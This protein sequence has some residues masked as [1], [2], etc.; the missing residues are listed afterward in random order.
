MAGSNAGAAALVAA[1]AIVAVVG[2]G[3]TGWGGDDAGPGGA[4]PTPRP[5]PAATGVTA[6]RLEGALLTRVPGYAPFGHPESGELGALKSTQQG[7]QLQQA[8][9]LDKPHCAGVARVFGDDDSRVR[10]APAAS[11]VFA[12]A[13]QL[14]MHEL[15]VALPAEIAAARVGYRV[16]DSCRTYRARIGDG[17][18]FTYRVVEAGDSAA[19]RLGTTSRTVGIAATT[20]SGGAARRTKI[21]HVAFLDRGYAGFVTLSGPRATRSDA[22]DLAVR[23]H[24][25]A[26][27]IIPG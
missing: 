8:A 22:E 24:E 3:C 6:E 16:P 14:T 11:V 25:E 27:R 23:A 12:R 1:S 10:K 4:R 13:P 17:G 19:E 20:G 21:W 5:T 2:T 18:W 7:N 15:L 9:T 26:E